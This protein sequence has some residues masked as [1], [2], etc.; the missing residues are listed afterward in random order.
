MDRYEFR[1]GSERDA[2][3]R[4]ERPRR[5]LRG[6]RLR[7]Q[8]GDSHPPLHTLAVDY[9]SLQRAIRKPCIIGLP[10]SLLANK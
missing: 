1:S 3:D 4:V 6:P 10:T 5:Q 2:T 9:R 7:S 8:G